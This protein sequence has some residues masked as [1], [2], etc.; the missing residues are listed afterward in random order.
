MSTLRQHGWKLGLAILLVACNM[1]SD[2]PEHVA[3][4]DGE[5][6]PLALTQA[7]VLGMSLSTSDV[8]LQEARGWK[9]KTEMV[10]DL[11]GKP[12][13][14]LVLAGPEA[15]GFWDTIAKPVKGA[16]YSLYATGATDKRSFFSYILNRQYFQK[17]CDTLAKAGSFKRFLGAG[18]GTLYLENRQGHVWDVDSGER[19]GPNQL[20][21]LRQAFTSLINQREK[22]GVLAWIKRDWDTLRGKLDTRLTPQTFSL[23]SLDEVT[24]P[25]GN[26][27]APGLI[28]ALEAQASAKGVRVSSGNT[29]YPYERGWCEGWF[30][31]GLGFAGAVRK[32][33][34]LELG[35]DPNDI[36]EDTEF[37]LDDPQDISDCA[38]YSS[39]CRIAKDI[40]TADPLGNHQWINDIRLAPSDGSWGAWD[41]GLGGLLPLNYVGLWSASHHPPVCLVCDPAEPVYR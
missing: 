4:S 34:T 29:A 37:K 41:V 15:S 27:D 18:G 25:D 38:N 32:E 9:F 1:P 2:Y 28:S 12:L 11:S 3:A 14:H 30:C 5:P 24:L 31:A 8:S 23:P 40:A 20:V 21:Q 22:D 17:L 19:V 13:N 35:S 39:R 7:L 33:R 10:Y 16:K 26:L 6:L 36:D